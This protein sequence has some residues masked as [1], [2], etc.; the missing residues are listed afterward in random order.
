MHAAHLDITNN[1]GMF[2]SNPITKCKVM[3]W[4]GFLP[5]A[6]AHARGDR[7]I[8]LCCSQEGINIHQ[9]WDIFQVIYLKLAGMHNAKVFQVTCWHVGRQLS[10]I[11]SV[12][13]ESLT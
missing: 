7:A 12:V 11:S 13:L 10:F 6:R 2:H 5:D 1:Q 8:L 4:E 9:N 3:I